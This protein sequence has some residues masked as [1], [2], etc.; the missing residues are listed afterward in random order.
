MP[1]SWNEICVKSR[2]SVAMQLLLVFEMTVP[3]IIRIY[4]DYL[5]TLL[6]RENVICE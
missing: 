6:H 4:S 3:F 5:N 1:W 2:M